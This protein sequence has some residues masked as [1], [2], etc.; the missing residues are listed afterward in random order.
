M[1]SQA[2]R[3]RRVIGISRRI[4]RAANFR[5]KSLKLCRGVKKTTFP[6]AAPIGLP[7]RVVGGPVGVLNCY[8]R[9]GATASVVEIV[10]RQLTRTEARIEVLEKRLALLKAKSPPR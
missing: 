4:D 7:A 9:W 3:W 6:K 2:N 8:T 5:Y 1:R 10:E